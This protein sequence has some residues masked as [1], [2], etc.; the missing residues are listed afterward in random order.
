MISGARLAWLQLRRQK[1]RF[2]VAIAGVAFAVI[3]MFMQLGFQDA[4]FRSAVNVH[5]RLLGQLF[6]FHPNYNV[7]AF[8]SSFPRA[9]LYQALS[10]DGV[11]SVT[12][13]Y[14]GMATWKNPETGRTRDI[15]TLGI[16]PTKDVFDSDEVRTQAH[17]LRHPDVVL[18]DEFSRPEFGPVAAMFKAGGDVV[19][20]A[21]NRDVTVRG[22]FKMGTSFGIDGTIFTSDLN[23]M[24]INT[25]VPPGKVGIGVVRLKPGTNVNAMQARMR[26][27]LPKDVKIVT[28]QEMIDHEVGY[29]STATPIGFVF[30]FGVV[31]GLVVGMIIVYQILFA[32]IS[33]H[34][35]EYATLKA[36]GYTNRYLSVVVLFEATILG[37]AGFFPGV[38]ICERLYAVTKQATMLPMAIEPVRA[39]QVLVLTLVMCWASAMIAMRKLRA[40]DP[41]DVF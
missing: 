26:A 30:T 31:M 9:R 16:D 33:D 27:E 7:L 6:F 12:P 11:E 36:M 2:A 29:W 1:V 37:I 35:K 39:S 41:A 22:L 21:R 23:F 32:D 14:T 34:L 5:R 40:A 10:F 17:L 19:T 28:K 15:F 4:L 18:Y 25:H 38:L 13:V 20:E 3:L 24:R 8:T